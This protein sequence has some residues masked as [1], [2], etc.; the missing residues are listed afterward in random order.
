MTVN[1]NQIKILSIISIASKLSFINLL[2]CY[3]SCMLLLLMKSCI[4]SNHNTVLLLYFCFKF[5]NQ[6]T[7]WIEKYLYKLPETSWRNIRFPTMRLLWI[8]HH[9]SRDRRSHQNKGLDHQHLALLH[10]KYA[11]DR[12]FGKLH[13]RRI[14]FL[15]PYAKTVF[16][17]IISYE[18]HEFHVIKSILAK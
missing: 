5:Q 1:F 8:D 4:K 14:D 18:K 7:L 16:L 13:V 10:R 2:T 15:S 3:N 9:G 11:K 17:N 6:S 12:I